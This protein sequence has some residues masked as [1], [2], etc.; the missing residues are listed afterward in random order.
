MTT[1]ADVRVSLIGDGYD[2][3]ELVVKGVTNAMKTLDFIHQ[4]SQNIPVSAILHV[5]F[6]SGHFM[7][8]RS[9]SDSMYGYHIGELSVYE[10]AHHGIHT[11]RV[12]VEPIPPYQIYVRTPTYQGLTLDVKST[13]TIHNVKTMIQD[14]Q[15]IPVDQQKLLSYSDK[16]LEDGRTL[17]SYNIDECHTLELIVKD[18]IYVRMNKSD[19]YLTID[20]KPTDT[21]LSVKTKIQAMQ[22]VSVDQQK[23]SYSGCQQL[24]NDHT[25]SDY[26]IHEGSVLVLIVCRINVKIQKDKTIT[27]D[28]KPSDTLDSVKAKIQEKE[29]IPLDRYRLFLDGRKLEDDHTLQDYDIDERKSLELIPLFLGGQIVVR[30]FS[31]KTIEVDVK[32]NDTIHTVKTK[33]Q[34]KEGYSLDQQSLFLIR[35]CQKMEDSDLLRD[36]YIDDNSLYLPIGGG[37]IFVKTLT[38][39]DITLE[40]EATETVEKLKAMIQNKEGIL[41]NQQRLIYDGK[42]LEDGHTIADYC[43]THECTLHLVLRL[44]GGGG[45]IDF[46]DVSRTDALINQRFSDSAPDWRYCCRGINIEGICEN[47]DCKAYGHMVIY[48][49]RFGVFDLINSEAKCPICHQHIKPIKPGFS[50]CLWRITYMKDD[51]SYGILPTHKVGDEYQTYD[52][53]EAGTCAYRFMHI[54]AMELDRELVNPDAVSSAQS[55]KIEKPVMVQQ[56]CTLCLRELSPDDAKVYVCGHSVH[57]SCAENDN[58]GRTK[59]CCCNGPLIEAS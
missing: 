57:K 27:L 54:E 31:E 52:E 50:S 58:T 16:E 4:I 48:M 59:C 15:G 14:K 22:G 42:Q 3:K 21:I 30:T 47:K 5:L 23:L 1:T 44:R 19:E 29:G 36:Y 18:K 34:E 10:M 13:D 43:I 7:N 25:L 32:P 39:K 55:V 33:I 40:V 35:T 45:P 12:R 9:L 26:K 49:Y 41:P 20:V 53:V 24:E 6:P 8:Y 37:M 38:G 56:Y 2:G 11:V 51:G 46:V 28:V 17:A